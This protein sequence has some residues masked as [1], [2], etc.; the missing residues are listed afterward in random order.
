MSSDDKKVIF[1]DFT[2]KAQQRLQEKKVRKTRK[3]YVPSLDQEI[4]I[5]SLTTDEI[6]ES[7]QIENDSGESS[8]ADKFCVY[9]SVIEPCLK[10]V[11]KELK[12]AGDIKEYLDVVDIFELSERNEINLQI[13]E[14]SGVINGKKVTVVEEL[15]N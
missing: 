12:D 14:L 10:D 8:R 15:K 6:A 1:A 9:E 7:I 13:L 11:A 2:R 4:T 5:Q 3:L